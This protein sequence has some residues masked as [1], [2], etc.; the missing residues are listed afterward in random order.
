MSS[1]D[2]EATSQ[3]GAHDSSSR[4]GWRPSLEMGAATMGLGIVL[5]ALGTIGGVPLGAMFEWVASLACRV[6]LVPMLARLNLY[7]GGVDH[8]AHAA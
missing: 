4:H 3:A 5:I 2:P 7:T 8:Q 1:I 6:M